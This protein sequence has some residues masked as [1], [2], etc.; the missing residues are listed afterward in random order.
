MER[1]HRGQRFTAGEPCGGD[2]GARHRPHH[3]GQLQ[4]LS[5]DRKSCA[6]GSAAYS[7]RRIVLARIPASRSAKI[8]GVCGHHHQ[9]HDGPAVRSASA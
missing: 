4:Y 1:A 6:A 5:N 7:R 9:R 8:L 2:T 3:G